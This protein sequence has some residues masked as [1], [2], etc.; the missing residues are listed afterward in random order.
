MAFEQNKGIESKDLDQSLDRAYMQWTSGYSTIIQTAVSF[1]IGVV[2]CSQ[3]LLN[4]TSSVFGISGAPIWGLQ[5]RRFV[6]GAG[7]TVIA[8]NGSS[9]LTLTAFGTSGVQA[10]V[11][12]PTNAS[13]LLQ[14]DVL[15]VITSVANTAVNGA[16]V[17]A[18]LGVLQSVRTDY[19]V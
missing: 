5:V 14:G 16:A 6:V 11:I 13:L 19:G 10:H 9:L 1:P 4:V 12:P 8:L 2:G 18:V 3:T 17:T 15:E 7:L